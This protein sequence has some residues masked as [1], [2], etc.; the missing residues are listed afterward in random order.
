M[1]GEGRENMIEIDGNTLEGGGQILRMAVAFS[2]ILK[3]PIK[4]T[5]IRAGRRDG[6]LK[7]QH[8]QGLLLAREF[9]DAHVSGASIGSVEIEYIPGNL[10]RTCAVADT[11]T[12]GSICLL[13]QVALP[14][15][16][17]GPVEGEII[18]RGGTDVQWAPPLDYIMEIF[19]HH[20]NLFGANFNIGRISRGFYPKGRGEV[21]FHVYPVERLKNV[22]I[23]DF[24]HPLEI[25]VKTL[26]S[27]RVKADA[28]KRINDSFEQTIRSKI[29]TDKIPVRTYVRIEPRESSF[30][31][32]CA[33]CAKAQTS[34]SLLGAAS[35]LE[36][37]SSFDSFGERLAL[38]IANDINNRVCADEYLQDQLIIFMALAPGVSKIRTGAITKH[39]KTAIYVSELMTSA[40]FEISTD[41]SGST[42]IIEC[43][44][45]GLEN[46]RFIF[47]PI[48]ETNE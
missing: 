29:D 28:A 38:R 23:T 6:G 43:S 32:G 39:T 15:L 24:G 9:C 37:N 27:G 3:L 33:S 22:D 5:N 35:V 46:H 7:S 11:H 31:D 8:L 21:Q 44:G 42:N 26:V 30:G 13:L 40:K 36:R 2:T 17:F 18:I 16:L 4:V 19:R 14:C 25:S 12:A 1:D 41:D 47:Q 34:K 10:T 48:I 45:I 20:L